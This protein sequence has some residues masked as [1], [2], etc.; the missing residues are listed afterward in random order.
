MFR[1]RIVMSLE[2][3]IN[4]RH[5]HSYERDND[6]NIISLISKPADGSQYNE[7][8]AELNEEEIQS[9]FKFLRDNCDGIE[10]KEPIAA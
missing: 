8:G 10:G 4:G 5:E 6:G 1:R 9:L 3:F 2:S 7:N